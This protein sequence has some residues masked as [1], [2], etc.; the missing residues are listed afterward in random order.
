VCRVNSKALHHG[1]IAAD[2]TTSID[3]S[4]HPPASP[5]IF[6]THVCPALHIHTDNKPALI[7]THDTGRR[8]VSSAHPSHSSIKFPGI[9]KHTAEAIPLGVKYTIP[10]GTRQSLCLGLR[11]PD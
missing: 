4:N 10:L 2:F 11:P 7:P 5:A 3:H 1:L 6:A 8:S 9:I